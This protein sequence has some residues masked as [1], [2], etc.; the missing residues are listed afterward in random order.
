MKCC[1]SYRKCF[2]CF[3]HNPGPDSICPM[4]ETA[5]PIKS[6]ASSNHIT[7]VALYYLRSQWSASFI[8]VAQAWK[9]S[10]STLPKNFNRHLRVLIMVMAAPPVASPSTRSYCSPHMHSSELDTL[11]LGICLR[12]YNTSDIRTCH[13]DTGIWSYRKIAKMLHIQRSMS[14]AVRY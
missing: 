13:S 6:W 4:W 9:E 2:V 3:L 14:E 11:H 12:V 8:F 7:I 1:W 5:V 10:T